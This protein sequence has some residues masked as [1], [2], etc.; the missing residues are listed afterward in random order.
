MFFMWLCAFINI[1]LL[2]SMYVKFV[3]TGYKILKIIS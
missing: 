3:N 2:K 1:K